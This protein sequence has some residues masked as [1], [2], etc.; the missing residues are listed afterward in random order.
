MLN[1]VILSLSSCNKMNT[2]IEIKATLLLDAL[3]TIQ[4]SSYPIKYEEDKIRFQVASDLE[5]VYIISNP[6]ILLTYNSNTQN[7]TILQN[8]E[9][10]FDFSYL[11]DVNVFLDNIVLD[12]YSSRISIKTTFF[13]KKT[14]KKIDT[15][16]LYDSSEPFFF[17]Q[18][19]LYR[20]ITGSTGGTYSIA[21]QNK[22][23][24][25][26]WGFGW[27]DNTKFYP[28]PFLD[29]TEKDD[30]FHLIYC[31]Y[32]KGLMHV[33]IESKSGNEQ[34]NELLCSYD[35]DAWWESQW[36][37][38]V[39]RRVI[40]DKDTAYIEG[41]DKTGVYIAKWLIQDNHM[42][43]LQ[44]KRYLTDTP[45]DRDFF[46]YTMGGSF[47]STKPG[48]IGLSDIENDIISAFII[49]IWKTKKGNRYI[50]DLHCIDKETGESR[51]VL[52]DLSV[53]NDFQLLP[54]D[55]FLLFA[56]LVHDK[57][58]ELYHYKFEALDYKSGQRKWQSLFNL[59]YDDK[60]NEFTSKL[61]CSKSFFYSF[62]EK[63]QML[64]KMD[65]LN[66]KIVKIKIDNFSSVNNSDF[67][68]INENLFL[69]VFI[70]NSDQVANVLVYQIE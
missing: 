32:D 15:K 58:T 27:D 19:N 33:V 24:E 1:F 16:E 40:W 41:Q 65:L 56:P 30:F 68:K 62:D 57:K 12:S 21:A 18:N 55:G 9:T 6:G 14:L 38:M 48:N 7:T 2:Q 51:W 61:A 13:D 50:F 60:E 11:Q 10:L 42:L 29:V 69:K 46:P 37:L 17:S 5:N 66:G 26:I 44:W 63:S 53:E 23:A 8:M 34:L 64:S 22:T 47:E 70:T 3:S 4:N 67:F 31:D 45:F 39:G 28:F 52:K 54:A 36:I 35:K 20:I 43:T 25:N 59:E 49:P